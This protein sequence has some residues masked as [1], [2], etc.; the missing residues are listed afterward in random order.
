VGRTEIK[1]EKDSILAEGEA[2]L[3]S[4]AHNICY[5]NHRQLKIHPH[6]SHQT[7]VAL[8]LGQQ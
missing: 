3:E 4:W 2:N 8:V 6:T 1:T 7:D 5:T